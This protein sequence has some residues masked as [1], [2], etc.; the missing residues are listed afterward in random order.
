MSIW[1][2]GIKFGIWGDQCSGFGDYGLGIRFSAQGAAFRDQSPPL[3]IR[4]WCS[5][6]RVKGVFDLVCRGQS[7]GIRVFGVRVWRLGFRVWR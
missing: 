3:R 5:G 4:V 7:F 1:R 2:D 6:G